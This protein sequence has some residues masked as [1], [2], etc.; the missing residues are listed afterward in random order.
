ME[1]SHSR[2]QAPAEYMD[3]A[4]SLIS[5]GFEVLT[6]VSTKMAVF[7]VVTLCSPARTSETSVDF[8]QTTR[9]Y[10]PE[11]NHFSL[12][13]LHHNVLMDWKRHCY[14]IFCLMI[15]QQRTCSHYNLRI[16]FVWSLR[17]FGNHLF[18]PGFLMILLHTDAFPTSFVIGREMERC[19]WMSSW[20][21]CERKRS[22]S[23]TI[24]AFC[25]G[26][27]ENHENVSRDSHSQ[28]QGMNPGAP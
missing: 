24:T 27:G 26:A 4:S 21:Q 13:T 9:R 2:E 17:V 14:E 8:Y 28:I 11:D 12:I 18:S 15:G 3:F 5:V 16:Y 20:K 6:A 19:E 22:L 25:E 10:N 1:L 7:W 23:C